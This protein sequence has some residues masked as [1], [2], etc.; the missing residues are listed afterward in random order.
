[1]QDVRKM[2]VVHT[3]HILHR[4]CVAGRVKRQAPNVRHEVRSAITFDAVILYDLTFTGSVRLRQALS[5]LRSG[6][7]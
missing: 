7:K 5:A 6:G 2:R 3:M 1:M 4:R